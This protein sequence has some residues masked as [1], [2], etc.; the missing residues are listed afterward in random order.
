MCRL[1]PVVRC[2][3]LLVVTY[4]MED[5]GNSTAED[6]QDDAAQYKSD[7]NFITWNHDKNSTTNNKDLMKHSNHKKNIHKKS[8]QVTTEFRDNSTEIDD[9]DKFAISSE[10]RPRNNS[11]KDNSKQMCNS[12]ICISI[13]CELG[14]RLIKGICTNGTGNYPF[15]EVYG[16]N[17]QI[18]KI[19][20]LVVSDPC[21]KTGRF[22]FK[23]DELPEDKY[24][25]LAN[26]SIYQP[27]VNYIIDSATYCFA[28]IKKDKYELTTCSDGTYTD[29]EDKGLV[30]I[31][32]SLIVSLPFFLLT[33]VV[34]TILPDFWNMHGYT[35]RGYIGSLFVSYTF[36]AG[37]QLIPSETLP[38]PVCAALG[39]AFTDYIIVRL[40]QSVCLSGSIA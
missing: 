24:V 33:F 12:T 1:H 4:A 7:V 31:T 3:L 22:L 10:L 17:K 29:T 34:Y 25:I 35:L 13:C 39:T 19:F 18:D 23:P 16:T 6:K 37:L 36:L 9:G 21:Q 15:P 30:S 8:S 5:Q 26:G 27:N 20:Q 40:I 38:E 2:V 28:L 32:V 11:D 14:Y